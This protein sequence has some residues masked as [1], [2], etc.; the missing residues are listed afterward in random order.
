LFVVQT[1]ACSEEED[2][3]QARMDGWILYNNFSDDTTTVRSDYGEEFGN[4]AKISSEDNRTTRSS[5]VN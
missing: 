3:V 5:R 4:D 2:F 1:A